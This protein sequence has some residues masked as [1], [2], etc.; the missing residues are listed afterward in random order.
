M[1]YLTESNLGLLVARLMRWVR[2][3]ACRAY[4]PLRAEKIAV[5]CNLH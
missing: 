1:G 2:E 5:T 3:C 4:S